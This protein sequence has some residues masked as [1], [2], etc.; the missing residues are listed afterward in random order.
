MIALGTAEAKQAFFEN[1]IV[2]I[3]Q[4]ERK[5]HAALAIGDAE[6]AILAPTIRATTRMIVRQVIPALAGRRIIL[7]HGAPLAIREIWPPAAPVAIAAIVGIEPLALGVSAWGE[8][9]T[10]RYH[11]CDN[12]TV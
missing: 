11:Y 5:A 1:R 9:N 4:R 2:A 12:A 6:Q 10:G 7:A 8:G 3:P